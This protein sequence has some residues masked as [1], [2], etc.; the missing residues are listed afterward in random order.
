MYQSFKNLNTTGKLTIKLITAKI[1][2]LR[3]YECCINNFYT[4]HVL[5]LF[6]LEEKMK[7]YKL[8]LILD[9]KGKLNDGNTNTYANGFYV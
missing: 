2:N 9:N 4:D 5:D 1:R 8:L 6:C 7:I 3:K